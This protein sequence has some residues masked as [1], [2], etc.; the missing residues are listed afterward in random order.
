MAMKGGAKLWIKRLSGLSII[1]ILVFIGTYGESTD[2]IVQIMNV[3]ENNLLEL[4]SGEEDAIQLEKIRFYTVVTLE[5]NEIKEYEVKL[6]NQDGQEISGYEPSSIEKMNKRPDSSGKLVFIPVIIFV[7]PSDG[8]YVFDNQGNNSL[9]VLDDIEIQSSLISD[10]IILVSMFSCCLGFPLG[11]IAL[12]GWLVVWRTKNKSP[13]KLI[14]NE[15]IMTTD[16]L[17]KQYNAKSERSM[18]ENGEVPAPFRDIEK[19]TV[20][21]NELSLDDDD[22]NITKEKVRQFLEEHVSSEENDDD[23]ESDGNWKN[24]DD[25]E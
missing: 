1:L 8:E 17:F 14:V 3:E 18:I 7:V 21:I 22:P 25:G 12:I 10:Q 15:Q 11:I 16:Q 13:Q 6:I 4:E 19:V 9:W 2:K 23:N 20:T 5:G 24:W